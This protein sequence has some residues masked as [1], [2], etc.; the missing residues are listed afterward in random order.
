MR[1]AKGLARKGRRAAGGVDG[2][3]SI[4]SELDDNDGIKLNTNEDDEASG[5]EMGV[6]GGSSGRVGKGACGEG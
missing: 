6:A 5:G 2:A 4:D 1:C 3:I